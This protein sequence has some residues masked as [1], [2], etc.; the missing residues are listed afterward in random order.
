MSENTPEYLP[1]SINDRRITEALQDLPAPFPTT[2][3]RGEKEQRARHLGAL[4]ARLDWLVKLEEEHGDQQKGL[5][6]N[7][8][9]R[10]ALIFALQQLSPRRT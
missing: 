2:R 3:E 9:E 8:A 10:N 4:R 7:R 5:H 6:Q 1:A